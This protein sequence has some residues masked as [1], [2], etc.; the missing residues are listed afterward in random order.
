MFDRDQPRLGAFRP[1][2]PLDPTVI[3]PNEENLQ[4]IIN[5]K[6]VEDAVI[7][8]EICQEKNVEIS[9]ETKVFL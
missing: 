4:K 9:K 6:Q 1:E 3:E 2:K 7:F 5:L 8:Y